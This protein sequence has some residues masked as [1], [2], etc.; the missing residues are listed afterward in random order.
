VTHRRFDRTARLMGDAAL[1]RLAGATVTVFGVG[2]VGSF[3][4]E[5]LARSGVGRIILVDFDRICVTNVNRQLHALKGT[6]G[7][8]KVVVMAERLR[9][10]NP[11][12]VVEARAEFYAEKS[13]AR[14]LTPEPDVI[15]DAI[16]NVAAKLHLIATCVRERLRLVSAMGAAARTDPTQVRV[17]DLAETRRDPFARELRK[18]LRKKHGLDCARPLGV[19][20]VY[21]EEDPIAPVPLAYDTDGFRCVCPGGD[22]GLSDCEHRNRIE[23]SAAF[24][25]SVIGM[26]AAACAVRLLT[27][28]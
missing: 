24:V 2:G 21:S 4:A 19:T 10:I 13:A 8:P 11:D 23:G 17:A 3:A 16:D 15:I 22:N 12:A 1:D 20:A 5:G 28:P 9:A 14:L 25:P 27:S 6:L 7:K 26:T 18:L